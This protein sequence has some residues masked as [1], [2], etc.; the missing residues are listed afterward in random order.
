MAM[1]VSSKIP[2]NSA[3]IQAEPPAP[4]LLVVFKDTTR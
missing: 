3:G 1:I 4:C 2:A